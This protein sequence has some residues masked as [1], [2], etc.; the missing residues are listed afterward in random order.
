VARRLGVGDDAEHAFAAV[1]EGDSPTAI[2]R[3]KRLDASS[4]PM[5]PLDTGLYARV[6]AFSSCRRCFLSTPNTSM[7]ED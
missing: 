7:R 2:A 5:K 4:L 3:L 1:A 6:R